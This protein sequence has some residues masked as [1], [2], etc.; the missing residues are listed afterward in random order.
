MT[1]LNFITENCL[2][3]KMEFIFTFV[4]FLKFKKASFGVQ[5]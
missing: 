4:E 3:I 1:K 5:I 2:K